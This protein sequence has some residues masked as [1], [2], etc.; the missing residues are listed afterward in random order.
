MLPEQNG[1]LA[2]AGAFSPDERAAVYRA[3]ETRRDVRDEFLPEPLPEDLVARLLAAAHQAPSVG[4]MQPWN[5]VLVRRDETRE[6]VWQAFRCAN[7]EAAEMFSGERQAKYRSLKLEGIRKAPLSI[8]VTCDRT[9]GGAVVLG[10]TH[11]PQMD[12]YSTV[13][14]VQNLWL[15]ARAEG[16]GVGWVSIFHEREIKAILGIPEHIEIVAW[17]CLGFV[18]KLYQE[19]ELAAKG[20]RQRLPL[21]DLVFEEGWGVR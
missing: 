8:C 6:K 13:C 4:F 11:N 5:F 17:L 20:W 12:L 16:V 3:I 21:E 7:D 10:R 19:P 15:A 2:A 18:D 9:R 14:A 1:C